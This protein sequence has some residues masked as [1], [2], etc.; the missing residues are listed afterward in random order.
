MR[1]ADH[2]PTA[3]CWPGWFLLLPLL[4]LGGCSE[5]PDDS[6]LATLTAQDT[7]L[8]SLERVILP[9]SYWTRRVEVLEK[10]V[11][12]ARKLF[13]DHHQSYHSGLLARREA[14]SKAVQAAKSRHE[15]SDE[16]RQE[17]I[18]QH[19]TAL[20][21]ARDEARDA[22]RTLRIRS[23]LLNKAREQLDRTR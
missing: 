22:G 8:E 7:V 20:A 11:E 18:Q 14:V 9:K 1:P 15:E 13:Q 5:P 17:A 21:Q 4:L 23:A 19:R 6:A 10:E 16:A 12:E 2:S 3:G